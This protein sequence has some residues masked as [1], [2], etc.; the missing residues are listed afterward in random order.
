VMDHLLF[1]S[2]AARFQEIAARSDT[3]FVRVIEDRTTGRI[4][5]TATLVIERKFVHENGIVRTRGAERRG[6]G[7]FCGI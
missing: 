3:Y 1:F 2:L 6:C 5:A 4:V 7:L